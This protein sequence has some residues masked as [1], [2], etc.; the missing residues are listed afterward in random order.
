MIRPSKT[1]LVWGLALLVVGGAVR[2]FSGAV[3][4]QYADYAGPQSSAEYSIVSHL[5]DLINAVA[6]PLGSAL[7][8]SSLVIAWLD[9]THKPVPDRG[10][11]P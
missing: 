2:V 8:A 9:P 7:I 10:E 11:S 6:F 4:E 5:L 3:L 1:V